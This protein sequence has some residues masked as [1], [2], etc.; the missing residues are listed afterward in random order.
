MEFQL[1]T[2]SDFI[3]SLFRLLLRKQFDNAALDLD[4]EFFLFF[5]SPLKLLKNRSII[6][7]INERIVYSWRLFYS[8]AIFTDVGRFCQY[9]FPFQK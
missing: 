9:P 6:N 4:F 3:L 2:E 8:L 7:I 1:W 5:K